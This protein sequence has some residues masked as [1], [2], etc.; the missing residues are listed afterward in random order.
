MYTARSGK[1][2]LFQL[3]TVASSLLLRPLPDSLHLT[4]LSFISSSTSASP[5]S[6]EI[7]ILSLNTSHVLLAGIASSPSH[8]ELVLLLWDLQYPVLLASQTLPIPSTLSRSKKRGVQITLSGS[9]KSARAG[10][11][12]LVLSPQLA[13]SETNEADSRSS[14]LVVPV[15]VPPT[16]TI[17]NAMGKAA[18]GAK[19]MAGARSGSSITASHDL[20][21]LGDK[22]RD[23]IK[24]LRDAALKK[25]ASGAEE[26]LMKY[27]VNEES[28]E[29]DEASIVLEREFI[30]RVLEVVL[31]VSG[32]TA[33]KAVYSARV[34]RELMKRRTVSSGMVQGGLI[35]A[36]LSQKDWVGSFHAHCLEKGTPDPSFLR[37]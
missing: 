30:R 13:S 27:I 12:L 20:V 4:S 14:V 23:V 25:G 8:P 35:P 36:L 32:D 5:F 31:P 28:Q 18:A 24:V 2:L 21:G 1:W 11:V 17:A 33:S 6:S 19:W 3:Q 22:Q 37:V 10:Q 26:V 9:Q 7:S 34:V 29:G 15:N 16:S